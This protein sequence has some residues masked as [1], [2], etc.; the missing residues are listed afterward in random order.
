MSSRMIRAK[1]ARRI[2]RAAQR[3]TVFRRCLACDQSGAMIIEFAFTIP[4]FVLLS[5]TALE[6]VN[7]A[8]AHMRVSQI[9][10]T[11]ADNLSRAKTSVPLGLPRLREV[12]VNDTLLG[13]GIQ[14]SSLFD[15]LDNGRIIVSSLQ[16]N[17]SGRQTIAWQ[18]CKGTLNVA[19]A[20]GVQG[21]TQPSTGTSG[22]QGMGRSTSLVRA[23]ANSAI[24]FAEVVYDYQPMIGEWL[25]GTIRLRKEAAYY[26]RD[27]RDL[28]GGTAGNGMYNPSP[29][30]TVSACN[31]FNASF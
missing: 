28:V 4:V 24:I 15:V 9:A 26:V 2:K 31:V 1:L 6:L 19:S 17:S 11:V 13:A 20:Y 25:L 23:E 29:S 7:L 5:M 14:G 21:A 12:D 10:M 27:D 18:R 22:F 8:L 3:F 30:A 16:R